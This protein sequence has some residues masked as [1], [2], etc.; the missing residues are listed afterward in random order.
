MKQALESLM[1]IDRLEVGPVRVEPRRLVAPYR[2]V[3]GATDSSTE[4][5]YRYEEDVFDPD[6]PATGNLASMIAAQLALN[7]GLFCVE[8][9]FHGPFDLSLI[10]I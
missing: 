5:V 8:I 10:H 6:D 9:V 2:V 7:Y 3:T 4:L 1:V